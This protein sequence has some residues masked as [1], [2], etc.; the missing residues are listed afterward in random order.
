[1]SM[2]RRSDSYITN[3]KLIS[4]VEDLFKAGNSCLSLQLAL[5]R[6][7]DMWVLS[8]SFESSV[9][10]SYF[11]S[12]VQSMFSLKIFTGCVLRR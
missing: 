4:F 1:V 5:R 9:T 2:E 6:M 7:Q 3:T 10:P 11:V 8:V 12:L